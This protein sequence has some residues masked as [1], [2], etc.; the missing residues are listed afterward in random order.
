MTYPPQGGWQ[1]PQGGWQQSPPGGWQDPAGG[2]ADPASG[3]PAYVDPISGQPAAYPSY[4]TQPPQP[5]Y[6]VSP[7][8]GGYQQAYP[9]YGAPMMAPTSR[10][11]GMSIAAMV[12]ALVGLL[13]FWC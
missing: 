2:Y 13:T 5:N 12:L 11:N 8:Y 6:P 4:A 7:E 10:T 3:Q 9:G 1:D